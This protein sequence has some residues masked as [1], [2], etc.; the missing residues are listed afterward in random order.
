MAENQHQAVASELD[1]RRCHNGGEL[2]FCAELF[3]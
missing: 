3:S 2:P 1:W